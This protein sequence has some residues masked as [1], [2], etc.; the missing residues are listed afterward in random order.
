MFLADDDGLGK[1]SSATRVK[2]VEDLGCK[3]WLNTRVRPEFFRSP[4]RT[5]AQVQH[6]PEVRLESIIRL[7]ARWIAEESSRSPRTGTGFSK[8]PF[9]VAWTPASWCANPWANL[10]ADDLRFGQV[11][12]RRGELRRHVAKKI[13]T[14]TAAAAAAG[15]CNPDT[16]TSAGPT[17]SSK[18]P[19]ILEKPREI[20]H[21]ALP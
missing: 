6:H 9:T 14:T 20:L 5:T 13:Q 4:G 7:Y 21:H 17:A 11:R 18:T 3:Y 19:Q 15:S 1:H 12:G 16:P 2:A 8:I 10:W